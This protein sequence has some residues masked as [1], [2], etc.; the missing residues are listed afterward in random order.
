VFKDIFGFL[1]SSG[2]L[3]YLDD[4]ELE[5]GC[6]KIAQTFSLEDGPSHVKVYDLVSELNMMRFSLL[7]GVMSS[8]WIFLACQR[9]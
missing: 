9:C 7:D 1:L 8:M 6:K 5:E 2:T 4:N 3:K